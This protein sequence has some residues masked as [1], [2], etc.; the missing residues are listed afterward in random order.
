MPPNAWTPR[1]KAVSFELFKKPNEVFIYEKINVIG[2]GLVKNLIQVCV[3]SPKNKELQN[4]KLSR[5]KFSEFLVQLKPSLVAFEACATAHYCIATDPITFGI[6]EVLKATITY[7]S[8][9]ALGNPLSYKMDVHDP[10]N[11]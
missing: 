9:D 7:T 3:V 1:L 4:K 8:Y 6:V 10:D 11:P 2:V 5:K